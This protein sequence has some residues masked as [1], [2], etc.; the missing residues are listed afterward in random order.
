MG[1]SKSSSHSAC[2]ERRAPLPRQLARAP[3]V[4]AV[5]FAAP[6]ARSRSCAGGA[7]DARQRTA[8]ASQNNGQVPRR[9][10]V[11]VIQCV[12]TTLG[13]NLRNAPVAVESVPPERTAIVPV[14]RGRICE[15]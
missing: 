8:A 11:A 9:Q 4:Q 6:E 1:S 13:S 10:R 5:Q 14:L 2:T 15:L 7:S 3:I 12:I